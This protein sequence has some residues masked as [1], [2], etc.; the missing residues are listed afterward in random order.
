VNT[1]SAANTPLTATNLSRLRWRSRR[2]LLENDLL[3]ER[4]FSQHAS[5]LTEHH[6]QGLEVLLDLSDNDLL[7]YLLGRALPPQAWPTA[8]QDVLIMM[9]PTPADHNAL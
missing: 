1:A 2:G 3:M 9:R 6:R 4:F 7:D 8:A 5:A